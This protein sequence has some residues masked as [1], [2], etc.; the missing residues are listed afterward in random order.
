MSRIDRRL[1]V[2]RHDPVLRSDD[3]TSPLQLGNGD[4][5]FSSDATGLQTLNESHDLYLP[6]ST[7]ANWAWHSAPNAKGGYYTIDDVEME[8]FIFE[9]DGRTLRY[10]LNCQ[11]GNEEPYNWVRQNPHKF[12]L[13]RIGFL[14]DGKP[15]ARE[16][17]TVIEQ[18]QHLYDG[19]IESRFIL[20]GVPCRVL[21]ACHPGQSM[22]AFIAKSELLRSGRLTVSASFPYGD[23]RTAGGVWDAPEKHRTIIHEQSPMSITLKRMQD[24]D[25]YFARFTVNDGNPLYSPD[26]VSHTVSI[27]AQGGNTLR[28]TALF[29]PDAP[30][31]DLLGADDVFAEAREYWVRFWERGA[32]L[33]LSKSSDS[34]AMELERRVVVSLYHLAIQAAGCMPSAETGLTCNSW[35]GMFH[36]EMHLWHAAWMAQWGHTD[37]LERNIAWYHRILPAAKRAASRNGFKGARWPKQTGADG[38]DRPSFIA[39][40][41]LW[42]VPHILYMLELLYHAH[43]EDRAAAAEHWEL[44]RETADFLADRPVYNEKTGRYDVTQPVIP[45][46]EMFK[47]MESRNPAFE[48]AYFKFGLGIAIRFAERLGHE[49]PSAWL[50]VYEKISPPP[51]R[52]G[53]YITHELFN[54]PPQF[55]DFKPCDAGLCGLLPGDGLDKDVLRT[56]F[57]GWKD[58]PGSNFMIGWTFAWFSMMATR[59]GLPRDALDILLKNHRCNEYKPN[60]GNPQPE[61]DMGNSSAAKG[62]PALPV[63]LP[64][65][66]ALLLALSMMAA[67]YADSRPAPGFPDDGGWVVEADGLRPLPF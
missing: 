19:F 21:S 16:Q 29:S 58:S 59:L 14:L 22:V 8:E 66:G 11:P 7:M 6:L 5:V 1:W 44:I 28:L 63:Y 52:D 9:K 40:L 3:I 15:I 36:L 45:S 42:Q 26:L 60:G 61:A 55:K 39:A 38:V 23:P 57:L 33:R 43:G 10:A 56:Q 64:G 24:R 65:N 32:A 13:G 34:R 50:D 17:I 53:I 48:L 37:L 35:F 25:I 51:M 27:A 49:P 4:F 67:G 20:D 2:S 47:A 18:R 62:A 12:N 41:L 30:S 54:P 31:E 46:N